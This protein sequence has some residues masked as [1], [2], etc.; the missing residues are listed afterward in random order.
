MKGLHGKYGEWKPG[1]KHKE[2]CGLRTWKSNLQ[3]C[4]YSNV[5]NLH[6]TFY[7]ENFNNLN[8][9]AMLC[10]KIRNKNVTI[11]GNS[12]EHELFEV[13]YY[14]L[15]EASFSVVDT[16]GRYVRRE[17]NHGC[18][19]MVHLYISIDHM[20]MREPQ[21]GHF[22]NISDILILNFG[23]HYEKWTIME[24]V[25]YVETMAEILDASEKLVLLRSTTPQHFP[26]KGGFFD[27]KSKVELSECTSTEHFIT[28]PT[29]IILESVARK[30]GFGFLDE[31]VLFASRW[32]LHSKKGDCTH[33]CH[34]SE[35]FYPQ[36]IVLLQLL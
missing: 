4:D 24:Y 21:L 23:L 35:L 5:D 3:C 14:M 31:F 7:N 6:F 19:G 36:I 34:T 17:Y 10:E 16:R 12:L 29:N 22:I 26:T 27:P 1:L 28:H 8:V 33:Y 15:D 13:L 30:Y 18:N 9:T 25:S 20:L 32:D 2:R 11:I